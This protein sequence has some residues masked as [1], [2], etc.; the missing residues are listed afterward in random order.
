[1]ALSFANEI[2]I[3]E[4]VNYYPDLGGLSRAG[5][6]APKSIEGP[7]AGSIRPLGIALN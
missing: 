6:G 2:I 4:I 5:D 7:D 3:N 1:M